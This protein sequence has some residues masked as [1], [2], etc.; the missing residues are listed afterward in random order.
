[1]DPEK[2]LAHDQKIL[3]TECEEDHSNDLIENL[4]FSILLQK[5]REN[6]IYWGDTI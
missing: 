4:A 5:A 1:M 3:K 6:Y 2:F